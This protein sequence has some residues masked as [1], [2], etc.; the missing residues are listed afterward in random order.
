MQI[1]RTEETYRVCVCVCVCVSMSVIRHKNNPLHL[2][3]VGRRGQTK[4]ERETRLR[5]A[6]NACRLKPK[7][8]QML[9]STTGSCH[10][11]KCGNFHLKVWNALATYCQLQLLTVVS[12]LH[13]K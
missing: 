11:V 2:Q 3:C 8:D 12:K 7:N 4:K 13:T 9:N 6:H 1:P 5:Y 10:T